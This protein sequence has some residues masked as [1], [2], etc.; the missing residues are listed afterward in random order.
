V[1]WLKLDDFALVHYAAKK[2]QNVKRL[3]LSDWSVGSENLVTLLEPL[4]EQW[5]GLEEIL[6]P[7]DVS[8]INVSSMMECRRKLLMHEKVRQWSSK[9]RIDMGRPKMLSPL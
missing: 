7:F 1:E 5:S 6:V 9:V 8:T 4:V 2:F 3:C